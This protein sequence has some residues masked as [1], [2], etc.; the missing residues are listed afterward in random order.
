MKVD[1]AGF[2]Q[3]GPQDEFLP[4]EALPRGKTFTVIRLSV[5]SRA[6]KF[7]QVENVQEADGFLLF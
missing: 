5:F 7:V 6:A 2:P 3:A 1:C 4:F